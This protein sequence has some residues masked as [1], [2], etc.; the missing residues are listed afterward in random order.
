MAENH[1]TP[2]SAMLANNRAK[3]RFHKRSEAT[4]GSKNITD[5]T[6][7]CGASVS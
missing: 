2:T 6:A 5:E 1:D 4:T 3:A 7:T